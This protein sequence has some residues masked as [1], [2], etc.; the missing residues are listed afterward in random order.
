MLRGGL[1]DE[2]LAETAV[3]EVRVRLRDEVLIE[4]RLR[5]MLLG[6]S[7]LQE[8]AHRVLEVSWSVRSVDSRL[9][10]GMGLG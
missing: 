5:P 1:V 6:R 2:I 3:G 8:T 7:D 10:I 9:P 4:P